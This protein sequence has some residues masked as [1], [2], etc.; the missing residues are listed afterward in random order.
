MAKLMIALAVIG[1]WVLLCAAFLVLMLAT[2]HIRDRK[3]EQKTDRITCL[4]T[5]KS[6]REGTKTKCTDCRIGKRELGS[7]FDQEKAM[8]NPMQETGSR[9]EPGG[10]NI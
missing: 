7:E 3:R 10:K 1:A 4:I 2:W 6:C 8:D 5:G 9:K